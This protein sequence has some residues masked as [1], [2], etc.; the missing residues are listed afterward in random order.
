[1]MNLKLESI[2]EEEVEYSDDDIYDIQSWGADLSFRELV[3]MYKDNDLLKPDLQRNYVWTKQEASRF[4][5]SILLGLPVPSIFLANEKNNK[6]LIIDGYQR[7]MTVHDYMEGFFDHEKKIF[8]LSNIESINQR[9]RNKTFLELSPDE[10][11]KI[12]TTTIHAIIFEQR[13]PQNSTGMYQIF[14]RIN[15]SG[16]ALK[17]QEIRNCVY[18]GEFNELLNKLNMN[19]NWRSVI[20]MSKVDSRMIDIELILRFLALYNMN[21]MEI[22]ESTQINLTRYLNKFMGKYCDLSQEKS[23]E[24]ELLFT[25]M[26]DF[27]NTNLGKKAFRRVS[28]KAVTLKIQPAIFDAVSIATAYF[29][30]KN[31]SENKD[32]HM[33]LKERYEKLLN[34]PE[35][36]EVTSKQTTHVKNI[37]RRIELAT[38]ILFGVEYEL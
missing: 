22:M 35:F 31:K 8:K 30:S 12:K 36:L 29:L 26:I 28:S 24:F 4:I 27:I 18:N 38:E 1:M 33:D 6:K 17:S 15:T 2:L 20:N 16:K 5:D 21:D 3:T 9:W 34:D 32:I 23:S 10:Q 7:I 14:E 25:R 37:I 13:Q 11:R 19:S